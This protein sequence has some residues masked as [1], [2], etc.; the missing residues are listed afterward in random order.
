MQSGLFPFLISISGNCH[1]YNTDM[2]FQKVRH[3]LSVLSLLAGV[4]LFAWGA[5]P[6]RKDVHALVIYP[7]EMQM[8]I[9]GSAQAVDEQ[10]P[11]SEPVNVPAI[12]EVRRLIL[13]VPVSIQTGNRDLIRLVFMPEA[14]STGMSDIQGLQDIYSTHLVAVEARLEMGGLDV[15]P[16][17]TLTR[18]L[19]PG[20]AVRFEWGLI[21]MQAR[22]YEGTVWLYL[23]F[24]PKDGSPGNSWPVSA[25][26][27]EIRASSLL[28]LSGLLARRLGGAGT[29]LGLALASDLL[30]G[31]IHQVLATT[32]LRDAPRT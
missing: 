24:M 28:G 9:S 5:W 18:P 4:I 14:V 22:V 20:Q 25:K 1:E 15:E 17:G 11:L 31:L 32:S 21:P 29:L 23:R 7:R 12:L 27:V 26:R 16:A 8:A 2:L 30:A 10:T 3:S 19:F 13:D 6:S